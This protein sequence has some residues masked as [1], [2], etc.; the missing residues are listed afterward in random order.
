MELRPLHSPHLKP[1]DCDLWDMLEDQHII[2]TLTCIFNGDFKT[3][4]VLITAVELLV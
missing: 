4:G 1:C 3:V 2:E